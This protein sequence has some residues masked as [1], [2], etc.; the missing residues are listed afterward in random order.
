LL[1]KP[2]TLTYAKY[3]CLEDILSSSPEGDAQSGVDRRSGPGAAAGL[4]FSRALPAEFFEQAA[5]T[6]F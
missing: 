2:Q 3:A 1:Q 6:C 4:S 5:R